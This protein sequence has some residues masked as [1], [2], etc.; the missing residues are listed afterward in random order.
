MKLPIGDYYVSSEVLTVKIGV[1]WN[2][3]EGDSVLKMEEA[4]EPLETLLFFYHTTERK[5]PEKIIYFTSVGTSNVTHLVCKKYV[6][7]QTWLKKYI[8]FIYILYTVTKS[9][10]SIVGIATS[11]GLDDR[12]V[13]V[14]VPVGAR[15]FFPSRRP[16]RLWGPPNLLSNGYRGLFPRG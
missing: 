7:L 11:Y 14:R 16:D 9:R 5:I 1:F 13:E 6:F 3:V 15:I 10:D 12:G 8:L 4:E 2:A